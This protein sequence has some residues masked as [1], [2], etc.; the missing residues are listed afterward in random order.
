MVGKALSVPIRD[1]A[2]EVDGNMA[3]PARA[4]AVDM[5]KRTKRVALPQPDQKADRIKVRPKEGA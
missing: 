2:R 5:E 4:F 3:P 1:D